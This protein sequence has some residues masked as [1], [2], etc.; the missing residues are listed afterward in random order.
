MNHE[1]LADL[2]SRVEALSGPDREVDVEIARLRRVT[3]WMRN[4][5]DT[6]NY[7]TTHCRYTSSLDAAMTL[8]PYIGEIDG[9]R[10]DLYNFEKRCVAR[11]Y[12]DEDTDHKVSAATPP[13]ALT[14]AA[15]RAID[16]EKAP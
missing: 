2:A 14:A 7:E 16:A 12:S 13:L 15:L 9:Q 1:S 5:N 11:V 8:V 6:A 3:V 10:F 4:Y